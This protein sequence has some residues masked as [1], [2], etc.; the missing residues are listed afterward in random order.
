M[1]CVCIVILSSECLWMKRSQR[2]TWMIFCGS[3]DV[4]LQLWVLYTD[5]DE[6]LRLLKSIY[7]FNFVIFQELIAEKMSERNKGLLASPFKRTSKFLTHPVFNRLV[8]SVLGTVLTD[9]FRDLV[10]PKFKICPS[11]SRRLF[12][13][14]V[15]FIA[16]WC[17]KA[18][19]MRGLNEMWMRKY[20]HWLNFLWSESNG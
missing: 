10:H 1:V 13:V 15:V 5:S 2:E 3:L 8:W 20:G 7:W 6:C 11:N 14:V 9:V 19:A 4:N 12:V 18:N 16:F 17:Q